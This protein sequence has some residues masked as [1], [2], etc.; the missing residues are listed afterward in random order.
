[1]QG[2]DEV[3][4]ANNLQEMYP[5]ATMGIWG[6]WDSFI[7]R[8]LSKRLAA[9]PV[10][11]PLF[12]FVLTSTNHPPYD[13]PADYQRVPRD[14]A[15]WRGETGSDTLLPNLDTYHYAADQLGAF[16][17]EVQNGPLNANTIV[18]A[19]GDHNVRS[20]GVYAQ[21]ARRYLMRQVPFVIWG[22]KLQCGNQ[23]LLPA[24]HR[25][26]FSTLL[27][28]A[29]VQGPYVNAGRDLLRPVATPTDPMNAAHTLFFTGEARNAQG[30]WQLGN[31]DSF[32]C[33]SAAMASGAC[34]FS[35]L[36]DQQE[37]ARFG[38]LDW[39]V[40]SSLKK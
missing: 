34:E 1:V 35:A 5:E 11:K 39:N 17:Q 24:S 25:D 4:D 38:L 21:P 29:G 27:P 10:D 14:M 9:Q 40:R 32:V 20:F 23:L 15:L 16:V 3:I 12:V 19:T 28:L 22:D 13:L 31:K 30:M 36:D 8:Y 18:A 7:F 37:R 26:M 33:S 2:F 6:V